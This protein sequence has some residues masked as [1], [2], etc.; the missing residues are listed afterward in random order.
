[1]GI[2]GVLSD[3]RHAAPL[4][5]DNPEK[6]VIEKFREDDDTNRM[7]KFFAETL[8]ESNAIKLATNK[9][10]HD[11]RTANVYFGN[12]LERSMR[13]GA[14]L[15]FQ[16]FN[17]PIKIK[18]LSKEEIR[19]RVEVPDAVT[20]ALTMRSCVSNEVANKR[21]YEL[22]DLVIDGVLQDA[23]CHMVLD[24]GSVGKE[25]G[26][27]LLKE[28][29]LNVTQTFDLFDIFQTN[30]DSVFT[31]CGSDF[32]K[33]ESVVAYNAGHAPY[34]TCQLHQ[35]FKGC[36]LDF[37]K[38]PWDNDIFYIQ[39][40]RIC[41]ARSITNAAMADPAHR[42]KL[43]QQLSKDSDVDAIGRVSRLGRWGQWHDSHCI[44]KSRR[45]SYLMPLVF[46]G[47]KRSW[48]PR[49]TKS[50]LRDAGLD[51]FELD[52]A[53]LEIVLAPNDDDDIVEVDGAPK[54]KAAKPEMKDQPVAKSVKHSND[55]SLRAARSKRIN[56]LDFAAHVLSDEPKMRR[57]DVHYFA[58]D[59]IM[60][61]FKQGL[62]DVKTFM[63][64]Q[65]YFQSLSR[66][67]I[68]EALVTMW[69]R[70][71]SKEALDF[72]DFSS[73]GTAT[74]AKALEDNDVAEL[75]MDVCTHLTYNFALV[76]LEYTHGLPNY[77][78]CLIS[79]TESIRNEAFRKLS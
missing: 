42:S 19:Y 63:A 40:P 66:G 58:E 30:L 1:M 76:E 4:H 21:R 53:D 33:K 43:W 74:K 69:T 6:A 52:E 75:A 46:M 28:L 50:P 7:V 20:G 55:E 67:A 25:H 37:F 31:A 64:Q 44:F 17:A 60:S 72:L 29:G 15:N 18:P 59:S 22:P 47:I 16:R 13:F 70:M 14:G 27:F 78:Q 39:Y 34:G 32:A 11:E 61:L 36:S 26:T 12:T 48:Y 56:T 9:E 23:T 77:F 62:V 24:R 41:R 35:Q 68:S 65:H 10:R 51:T 49:L 57:L 8:E 2:S 38:L 71:G 79:P 73:A 5:K 54:P 45:P 3:W